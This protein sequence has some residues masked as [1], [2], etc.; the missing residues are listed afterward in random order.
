MI[1]LVRQPDFILYDYSLLDTLPE[2]EWVNGFAE[3]IKHACIGDEAMFRQLQQHQLQDFRTDRDLLDALIR[4]N[5]L[6]KAG[7]VQRDEQEKG[8]RKLLNFGHTLGHAIENAYG[9]PHGHAVSVGMV[10]AAKV[11]AAVTGFGQ[12]QEVRALLEQ[13]G[14]SVHWDF[15]PLKAWQLMQADKKRQGDQISYILLNAIGEG[16]VHALAPAALK[17][18]LAS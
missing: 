16:C 14:L 8:E 12:A 17:E 9:L 13:Y 7:V 18:F 4:K 11:S 2:E 1:G 5:A 15:D 3:I 6:F 10:F